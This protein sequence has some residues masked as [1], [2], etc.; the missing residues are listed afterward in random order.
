MKTPE[1]SVVFDKPLDGLTRVVC[2]NQVDLLSQEGWAVVAFYQETMHLPCNEQKPPDEQNRYSPIQYTVYKPST[3]TKF[4]MQLDEDSAL[5]KAA[6]DVRANKQA[7]VT[8]VSEMTKA[9]KGLE[10]AKKLDMI[11]KDELERMQRARDSARTDLDASRASTRKLEG[12]IAKIRK[13]VGELKMKEI[14]GA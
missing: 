1:G 11:M 4:V 9:M 5:A 10:E 7:A 8:A 3:L 12:D 2:E 13:A 14:L 6:V